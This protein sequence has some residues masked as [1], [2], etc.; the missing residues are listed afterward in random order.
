MCCGGVCQPSVQDFEGVAWDAE[1]SI[2]GLEVFVVAIAIG[3][4]MIVVITSS[5]HASLRECFAIQTADAASSVW[6]SK[7]DGRVS[8]S[9]ECL[10]CNGHRGTQWEGTAVGFCLRRI[11]RWYASHFET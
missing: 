2:G 8:C 1:V 7:Q 5:R 11:H 9:S 10:Q 4:T 3:E 6:H